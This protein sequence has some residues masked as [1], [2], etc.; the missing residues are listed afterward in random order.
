M[1][2][3]DDDRD[4]DPVAGFRQLR[5]FLAQRRN[6]RAREADLRT[7]L[8]LHLLD[9]HGVETVCAADAFLE[10]FGAGPCVEIVLEL[11]GAV[12]EL[13]ECRRELH[14]ELWVDGQPLLPGGRAEV[15]LVE[16]VEPGELGERLGESS[17]R[18]STAMSHPP[19]ARPRPT[20]LSAA[21]C[22]PR[23]SPLAAW[24]AMRAPSSGSASGRPSPD[25]KDRA[26]ASTVSAETSVFPC[27]A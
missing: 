3:P 26:I 22:W 9:D 5:S 4:S 20:T 10:V 8:P 12:T 7:R 16:V 13:G 18:R 1:G 2:L 17:T 23:R 25:P 19:Y 24:A 14:A 6:G 15:E 27:A 21:A 11:A